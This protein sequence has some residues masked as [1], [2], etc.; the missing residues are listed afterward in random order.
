MV[1]SKWLACV[2]TVL[3]IALAPA[4]AADKPAGDKPDKKERPARG[5]KGGNLGEYSILMSTVD[6]NE[7]LKARITET[8]K[9][10][11][12]AMKAWEQANGEKMKDLQKRMGDAKTAGDAEGLKKLQ[13]E[14]KELLAGRESIRKEGW[15][16]IMGMLSA[17]QKQ[18][19]ET[20]QFKRNLLRRLAKA[21]VTDEQKPKIEALISEAAPAIQAASDEKEK[22]K[23]MGELLK[24]IQEQVLTEE[25]KAA[26]QAK[27]APRGEHAPKKEKPAPTE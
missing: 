12:E 3:A 17:E 22:G 27:P 11:Q 8:A 24:K 23:L 25:Q 21:K 14:Q 16:K 2:L 19:W 7:Q 13:A 10:N 20:F 1:R 26:L 9:A 4:I 6:A 18:K 5:E 15:G